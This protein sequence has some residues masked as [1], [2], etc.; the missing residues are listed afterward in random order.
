MPTTG[1]K[2]PTA[3]MNRKFARIFSKLTT[4]VNQ[5]R[6]EDVAVSSPGEQTHFRDTDLGARIEFTDGKM[7]YW[8]I[9]EGRRLQ[10]SDFGA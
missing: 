1:Y 2:E 9:F 3:V 7:Y 6:P 5:L 8:I 4:L 10:D